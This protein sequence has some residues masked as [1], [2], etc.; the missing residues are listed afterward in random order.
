MSSSLAGIQDVN[1]DDAKSLAS[2]EIRIEVVDEADADKVLDMLKEFF[3]QVRFHI[4]RVM[5]TTKNQKHLSFLFHRM[6]L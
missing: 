3:F 2:E 1:K 5:H 6:S 4:D